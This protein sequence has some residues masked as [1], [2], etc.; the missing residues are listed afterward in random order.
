ML[1]ESAFS[2]FGASFIKFN[3]RYT[4][5]FS[6]KRY[7]NMINNNNFQSSSLNTTLASGQPLGTYRLEAPSTYAVVGGLSF[8]SN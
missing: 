4:F 1:L 6:I 8:Y 2:L 3:L 5:A 7:D